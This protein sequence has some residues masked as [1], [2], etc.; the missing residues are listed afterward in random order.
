MKQAFIL[1]YQVSYIFIL[2]RFLCVLKGDQLIRKSGLSQGRTMRGS[3]DTAGFYLL[4]N[5]FPVKDKP[6]IILHYIISFYVSQ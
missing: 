6:C 3:L 4:L 1:R 2:L 5:R